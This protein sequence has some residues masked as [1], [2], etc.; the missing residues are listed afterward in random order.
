LRYDA[1]WLRQASGVH[2]HPRGPYTTAE[3]R[4]SL[5]AHY[6]LVGF[7]QL[8]GSAHPYTGWEPAPSWVCS[9]PAPSSSD[10][11]HRLPDLLLPA[12]RFSQPPG[13]ND[14]RN[15]LRVYSTPLALL[16]FGLQRSQPDRSGAVPSPWLLRRHPVLHGF[17]PRLARGSRPPGHRATT[18]ATTL[19]NAAPGRL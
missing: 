13:R 9:L 18:L 2:N 17:L 7:G 6:P 14:V 12:L 19:R 4:L 11:R 3:H 8:Q 1:H 10:V 15:D 16:G 5:F